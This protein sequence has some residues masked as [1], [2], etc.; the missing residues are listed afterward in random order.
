MKLFLL[1]GHIGLTISSLTEFTNIQCKTLDKSVAE[2]EYCYIKAVNRTYKY[3]SLKVKMNQ[4]PIT[5]TKVNIALLKRYNGY[6]PFLYNYT[7]DGCR[8]LENPDQ[9]PI[10]KYFGDLYLPFTNINHS[11]PFNHDI[12]LEKLNIQFLNNHLTKVLPFPEGDYCLS[13]IWSLNNAR[14]LII[15]TYVALSKIAN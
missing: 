7:V 9:N 12:I 13:M 3:I 10:A 4:L 14:V 5:T 15:K 6:K 1:V 8:Y 2:F 11:C